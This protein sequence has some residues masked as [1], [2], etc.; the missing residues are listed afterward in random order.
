[1]IAICSG[2][3]SPERVINGPVE[4]MRGCVQSRGLSARTSLYVWSSLLGGFSDALLVVPIL[5]IVYDCHL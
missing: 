2:F 1:M 5:E 4:I 3:C